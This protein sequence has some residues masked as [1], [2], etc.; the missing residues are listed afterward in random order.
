MVRLM[1]NTWT[2]NIKV[3]Y[4]QSHQDWWFSY[5]M[6]SEPELEVPK[7]TEWQELISQKRVR[8]ILI[9]AVISSGAKCQ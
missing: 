2:Y 7:N 5:T 9:T 6:Y 4:I 8:R 1:Y 3:V